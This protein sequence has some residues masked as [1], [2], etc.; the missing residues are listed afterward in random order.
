MAC[1]FSMLCFCVPGYALPN[2]HGLRGHDHICNLTQ[3]PIVF[4]FDLTDQRSEADL[5]NADNLVASILK[6]VK[7]GRIVSTWLMP[8]DVE[9]LQQTF[10]DCIPLPCEEGFEK[11]S[12]NRR[13]QTKVAEEMKASFPARMQ[14]SFSIYFQTDDKAYATSPIIESLIRLSA[15]YRET[16]ATV[17]LMS[18]GMQN[19]QSVPYKAVMNPEKWEESIKT[20][21]R[22]VGDLNLEN[23]DISFANAN[24]P[25]STEQRNLK[26]ELK[27]NEMNNLYNFW[28]YLTAQGKGRFLGIHQIF[29]PEWLNQCDLCAPAKG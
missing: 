19:T 9:G 25:F 27:G 16:G 14:E 10:A 20:A 4:V 5:K 24:R 11:F 21:H 12:T 2:S 29:Q 6:S 15:E 23:M 8:G 28:E 7:P 13:C 17:I 26:I 3:K 1:I 22:K 18:D